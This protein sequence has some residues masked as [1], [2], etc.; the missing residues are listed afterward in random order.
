MGRLC[1]GTGSTPYNR[2]KGQFRG[3]ANQRF[4][5]FGAADAWHL[6]QNAPFALPLDRRFAR[7]DLV[8][9]PAD[10]LHR[11]PHGSVIGGLFLGIGERE[12]QI[13]PFGADRDIIG[14]DPGQRNDGRARSRTT[15]TARSI[16]AGSLIRTRSSSSGPSC[17]RTVPIRARSARRALR[18]SGH[19]PSSRSA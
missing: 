1:V 6:D 13:R 4:Q 5:L 10:D 15:D 14:T 11:L 12:D 9:P 19:M 2:V 18:T 3:G 7:P 17:R 8:D 16:S